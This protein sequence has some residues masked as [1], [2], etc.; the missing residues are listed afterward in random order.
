MT[1]DPRPFDLG[2]MLAHMLE[3]Y[4]STARRKGIALSLEAETL[5]PVVADES[6]LARVVAN[7]SATRSSTRPAAGASRSRRR[8]RTVA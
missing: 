1:L 3:H 2:A 4:D 8:S 5:P 6:Q 7:L